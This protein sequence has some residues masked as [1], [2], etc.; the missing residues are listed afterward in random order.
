M[1]IEG[2]AFPEALR[3]LADRAGV[4]LRRED[5]N[6]QSLRNRL[7]GLNE[8]AAS[9]FEGVLKKEPL[10]LAYLKAR[11]LTDDTQKTF[12]IGFAPRRWDFLLSTLIPKGFQREELA[13]AGLIIQS[14]TR[15]SWYDRFRS[16]I[17]FPIADAGGR[18]VGFGG[19]I[20]TDPSTSSTPHAYSTGQTPAPQEDAAKYINTP[21]TPIY[22]KSH[23]LYGFDK[24]KHAIRTQDCVVVVEGYMDCVMSHQAGVTHTIAVSGTALTTPQLVILKRLCATIITSFDTDGAGDSATKRS[25]SL[26]AA[27]EFTRKVAV[28][29]SG[30]DP[31]DAVHDD[32]E[33]WR[34]AVKNAKPVVEFFF[35]K[36]FATYD[37]DTAEGKKQIGALVFPYITE[38]TDAI[39]K[40]HWVGKIAERFN[41][42]EEAVWEEL[43]KERYQA[44]LEPPIGQNAP[45]ATFAPI[46]R[47]LSRRELLEER[48]LT[49]LAAVDDATRTQ[50]LGSHRV[51][52]R[53]AGH[54]ELF[55]MVAGET[56][57]LERTPA[58]KEQL[59]L[60]RLKGE[61]LA[62]MTATLDRELASCVRELEKDQLKEAL[63]EVAGALRQQE[64]SDTNSDTEPLLRKF[65]DLSQQ[66]QQ[67][68]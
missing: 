20:F 26:A 19:R 17:I 50:V 43:S 2:H 64:A 36:A 31:A 47:A 66:L 14:P 15:T 57:E 16:R 30:K 1:E 63:G 42:K 21:Q 46:A 35:Q 11:G 65:R 59:A 67:L 13:Q 39:E 60:L 62:Q 52:F 8:E 3:L 61:L 41:V 44:S 10:V 40:A 54:S 29:P 34:E 23:V 18:V 49:A 55:R 51:V 12:R 28:I 45:A 37:P 5:P 7:Y 6:L 27:H 33:R 68:A 48:F 53:S 25:L 22:D 4:V 24:A 38:L 9:L 32:P 56:P 58:L